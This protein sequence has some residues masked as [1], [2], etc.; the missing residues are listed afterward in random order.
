MSS[1]IWN[2]ALEREH[3][4]VLVVREAAGVGVALRGDEADPTVVVAAAGGAAD[5]DVASVHEVV[6]LAGKWGVGGQGRRE[7]GPED[8]VERRQ[9]VGL[10]DQEVLQQR[11]HHPLRLHGVELDDRLRR[12]RAIRCSDVGDVRDR[13]NRSYVGCGRCQTA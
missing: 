5:G 7:G 11:N 1:S 2:E 4:M 6:E 12:Q 9:M 8:G 10:E 3:V 13:H